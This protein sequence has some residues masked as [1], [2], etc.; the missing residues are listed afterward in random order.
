M[1]QFLRVEVMN[2]WSSVEKKSPESELSGLGWLRLMRSRYYRRPIF[3]MISPNTP[4]T[5]ATPRKI[6]NGM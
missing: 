6:P 4:T 3:P 5:S 2:D 1:W